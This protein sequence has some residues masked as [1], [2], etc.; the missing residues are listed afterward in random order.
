VVIATLLGSC[1]SA[2]LMDKKAGVSGMNHF[3]LPDTKDKD[4]SVFVS[5]SGLYGVNAMELLINKMM[6]FGASRSNLVAKVFG[7]GSVLGRTDGISKVVTSK[8]IQF[9]EDY[10]KMENIPII[11]RDTGGLHGRKIF[12]FTAEGKV[13]M[14]KVQSTTVETSIETKEKDYKRKIEERTKGQAKWNSFI[15]DDK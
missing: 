9:V 4:Q 11:N 7:G 13:L 10:L 12:F 14:R 2:C 3:L 15:F 1:I 6:K 5:R 8:N